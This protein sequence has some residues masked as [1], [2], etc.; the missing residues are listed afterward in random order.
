[1]E[2]NSAVD[3]SSW[4]ACSIP[5]RVSSEACCT[6]G[7]VVVVVVVVAASSAVDVNGSAKSTIAVVVRTGS[8]GP[9]QEDKIRRCPREAH[10]LGRWETGS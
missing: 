9:S 3:H 10:C 2:G 6:V 7:P 8:D 4:P 1:M 5:H